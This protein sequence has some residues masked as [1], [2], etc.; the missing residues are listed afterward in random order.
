MRWLLYGG[1][2]AAVA[3]ALRRHGHQAQTSEQLGLVPGAEPADVFAVASKRQLDIITADSLL[4]TAPY[5]HDLKFGRTIVFLQ[6]SGAD[7]EQDDAVDRLFAR[8]K[9]LAAGRLYTITESRV[10]I[11][12]LPGNL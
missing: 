10:K 5:E 11:R 6:L 1:L 3:D 12:Q 2:T 4:A 9:R 8:Y 7:I